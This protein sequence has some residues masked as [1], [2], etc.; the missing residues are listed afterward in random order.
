MKA[1][2]TWNVFRLS[3]YYEVPFPHR[4]KAS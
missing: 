1:C 3:V 4:I 2:Y